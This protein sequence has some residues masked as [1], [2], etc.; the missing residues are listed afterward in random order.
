MERKRVSPPA[1]RAEEEGMRVIVDGEEAKNE[2]SKH[3]AAFSPRV[4][5]SFLT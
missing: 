4:Y 3:F 1:L 2:I 5:P